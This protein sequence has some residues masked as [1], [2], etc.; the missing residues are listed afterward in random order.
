MTAPASDAPTANETP[1]V[2]DA[3]RLV[4]VLFSPGAVFA[5]LSQT[6]RFWVPW[7]IASVVTIIINWF[8]R[9]FQQR[10]REVM[11][12]RAGQPVTPPSAVGT[13][14]GLVTGPLVVLVICAIVAGI[15]Y[16]IV[17]SM[18]GETTFKRILSVAIHAY[19]LTLIQQALTV[20]VLTMRGVASVNGPADMIVSLGADLLLPQDAQ[21]GYFVRFLLAGIGPI[22]IWQLAITA[23]GLMAMAKLGKGSAWTA[24]II[25][26]VILLC[27]FSALGAVGMKFAGG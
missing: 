16:L 1:V 10:I 27:L 5:E 4:R 17:S 24:A 15:L 13:L 22:Q 12:E 14:I 20:A 23:V 2:T 18:G 9:P 21:V 8:Q 26:F 3:L 6:P 11:L 7:A 25:N 19:P